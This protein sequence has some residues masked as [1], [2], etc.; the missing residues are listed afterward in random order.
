MLLAWDCVQ[1]QLMDEA[2]L[3]ANGW[4]SLQNGHRL[5]RF[6]VGNLGKTPAFM[7]E[8]ALQFATLDEVCRTHIP[9]EPHTFVDQFPPGERNRPTDAPI[10]ITRSEADVAFGA[11]WYRDIWGESH[12]SRFILRIAANGQTHSNVPG[13]D[14]AYY[15][16][17]T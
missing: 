13:V 16:K 8:Y 4:P 14:S 6:E 9:F 11:V 17:W 2:R 15:R 7:Y 1:I 10:R 3:R 5:F 12:Y